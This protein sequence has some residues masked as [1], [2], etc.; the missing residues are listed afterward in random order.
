M[1]KIIVYNANIIVEV[2][3]IENNNKEKLDNKKEIKLRTIIINGIIITLV[4]SGI[5]VFANIS[6][7]N[8]SDTPPKPTDSKGTSSDGFDSEAMVCYKPIIYLYPEKTT[9][10]SVKLGKQKI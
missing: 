4:V 9:E 1:L 10:I 3:E 7:S 2:F 6:Q 5:I 8:K